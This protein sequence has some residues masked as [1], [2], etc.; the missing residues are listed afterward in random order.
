M[1]I[2]AAILA[3][4]LGTRMGIDTPKQFLKI[5]NEYLFIRTLKTFNQSKLF[6][7]LFLAMNISIFEEA[8]KFLKNYNLL[9]FVELIQGGQ[10]RQQSSWNVIQTLTKATT[11]PDAIVIHDAARCFID[12]ETLKRCVLS[13]SKHKAI[14]CAVPAIDTIAEV[15]GGKVVKVPDRRSLWHIQTPQAFHFDL[16]VKAHKKALSEGVLNASDDAQLV[17]RYGEPVF[18]FEGDKRNIKVTDSYDLMVAR[19]IVSD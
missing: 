2:V 5:G 16:I 7:K 12:F 6:D 17:I 18:I 8:K 10:T 14:T 15:K 4:G 3:G 13:L 19:A 11:L 9:D 1:K